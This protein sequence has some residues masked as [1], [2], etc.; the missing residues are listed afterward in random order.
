V[1][2]NGGA[3]AHFEYVLRLGDNALILGQRLS[4]WCGHAPVLEEDLA[5]A[6][7]ALDLIGQARALLTHAG[8]LDG[9]GRDEDQ[10]A[11]LRAESEYRNVTLVELPEAGFGGT[12][13]RNF[14]FSAFQLQLWQALVHSRDAQLAEIAAKSL[15]ETRYHLQH[16]ADWVVRLGDGTQKSHARAQG[17]LDA[18]W[19]YTA[20]F[21]TTDSLDDEV[22]SA[23]L[24]VA[25]ASLERGWENATLPVLEQATLQVPSRTAFRS[26]GKLGTHSEH[27]GHL[28]TEMQYLQR[29]FPGAHW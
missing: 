27:M 12:V 8:Q 14:L 2:S 16:S 10:L 19:P 24:G 17:A 25:W 9:S 15:K 5:L 7:I 21:F 23:G 1:K 4:G 28:L 22:A 11:F 20:E 29:A 26:Q 6:N 3:G 13:V 18:L